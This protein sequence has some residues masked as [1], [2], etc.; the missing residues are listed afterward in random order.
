MYMR[1][2]LLYAAAAIILLFVLSFLV[3]NSTYG[4]KRIAGYL[5]R[6]VKNRFGLTLEIG[7]F[8]YDWYPLAVRLKDLSI[9]GS[10]QKTFFSAR[11]VTVSIPYSSFRSN[12]FVVREIVVDSPY[13]DLDHLPRF[14]SSTGGGTN[15]HLER[16]IIKSGELIVS[17]RKLEHINAIAIVDPL[18][19]VLPQVSAT[20]GTAEISAR[21]SISDFKRYQFQYDVKGNASQISELSKELPP[22][23]GNIAAKGK[24]EGE[25]G[26]FTVTGYAEAGS[27]IVEGSSPF[28]L[29]AEYS[30]N[31]AEKE[32]PYSIKLNWKSLPWN[33]LQKYDPGLP[34]MGT[35]I[36]GSLE[37][38]GGTDL[39]NGACTIQAQLEKDGSNKPP[40]VGDLQGR[41]VKQSL[42]LQSSHLAIRSTRAE[43]SGI[44]SQSEMRL[45]VRA[46]SAALS[47][48]AFLSPKLSRIAGAYQFTGTLSGPYSRIQAKGKLVGRSQELNVESAGSFTIGSNLLDLTFS[49]S[50]SGSAIKRLVSPEIDGSLVFSGKANGSLARPKIQADLS[51]SELAIKGIQLGAVDATLESDGTVMNAIGHFPA[52]STNAEG[53]YHFSSEKYELQAHL[54]DT[55]VEPFR[56]LLPDTF[57]EYSGNL[58]A[59]LNASG[60]LSQLK[61][62]IATLLIENASMK[63]EKWEMTLL[64]DSKIQVE[65]EM[66]TVDARAELPQGTFH[67]E[68]TASLMEGHSMNLHATGDTN[69]SIFALLMPDI[70]VS[71]PISMDA[72]INGTFSKPNFSGTIRTENL[73]LSLPSQNLHLTEGNLIGEFSGTRVLLKGNALINDAAVSVDGTIPFSHEKGEV[74]LDLH[75]FP[76]ATL[77]PDSKIDGTVDVSA[78]F[79]GLGFPY[80]DLSD[81]ISSNSPL[82]DWDGK[83]TIT[84]SNLKVG[85]RVLEAKQPLTFLLRNG[86]LEVETWKLTSGEMLDLAARGNVRFDTGTIDAALRLSVKVDLLSSLRA[87]I[88]SDG[89]LSV[90]VN[91]GGTIAKPEYSGS[92]T[93]QN[94]SLRIPN[95]QMALEQ[96]QLHAPFDKDH[97]TI[98]TL[99]A[100]AG[101]G[102]IT[103]GGEI[104]LSGQGGSKRIW[105]KG[106]NVG[107]GYPVGLRSQLDFD[108]SLG[109]VGKEFLLSGDVDVLR[110][111]YSDDFGLKN[112]LLRTLL[113]NRKEFFQRGYLRSFVKLALKIKTIDNFRL[114]NNLGLVRASADLQL[115]GTLV[116]PRVSGKVEVQGGSRVYF[117]GRRYDVESGRVDFYGTTTLQPELNVTLATLVQDYDNNT[118]YEITLPI[119]GPY[120]KLEYRNPRSTPSLSEDQIYSLLLTGSTAGTQ[121]AVSPAL[122]FQREMVAFLSGQLFFGAEEKFAKTFGLSRINVEQNLL[123]TGNSTDARLILGKDFGTSFTFTYSFPLS[124]PEDQTW[125][126][127]YRYHRNFVFR[128]IRQ[129]DNSVTASARQTILFGK[130]VSYRSLTASEEKKIEEPRIS[131]LKLINDSPVNDPEVRK[132]IKMSEGDL[133]DYWKLQDNLE[134]LEKYLQDKGYLFPS[135]RIEEEDDHENNSVALTIRISSGQ[136]RAMTFNG[137]KIKRGQWDR[138]RTWWREGISENL[139]IGL[140]RKDLL[141][142][143][144]LAGFHQASVNQTSQ[145]QNGMITYVF[146]IEPGIQFTSIDI[147]FSG[148]Q[149]YDSEELKSE[150]IQFY[151]SYTEMVTE[152]IHDF[153]AFQE[154]IEAAY[155]QKG[156]LQAEPSAGPLSI[157][158]SAGT[159]V[160]VTNIVEGPYT[161]IAK[162]VISDG[163]QFPSQLQNLLI[164]QPGDVLKL[165]K[166]PE[167]ETIIRNYYEGRGY[168]N[169]ELGSDLRR[170]EGTADLIVT[171][172]MKIGSISK[173]ASIQIVGNEITRTSLIEDRLGFKVGDI[174]TD[175]KMTE[176]QK[177]L[178]DL[179]VFQDVAMNTEPAQ[180]P[181]EIDLIIHIVEGKKYELQYG[182]RYNTESGI[183][184]EVNLIDQ[185]FLGRAQRLSIYGRYDSN[186]PLYRLDYSIPRLSGFWSNTLASIFYQ[187]LEERENGEFNGQDYDFLLDTTVS[188][189][190]LQQDRRFKDVFRILY[191]VQAGSSSIKSDEPLPVFGS[192][193]I[194]G[195]FVAFGSSLYV[196]TRN[197]PLNAKRGQFFSIGVSYAPS[198]GTDIRFIRSYNQYFY[199]KKLGPVIW[200]SGIRAGFLN[201]LSTE[202]TLDERFQTGGSNTVRGF[203][204]NKL[205]PQD[206]FV[207]AVFGGEAV[208]ILNQEI[209]FPI[210][211]WLGGAVF[212][213]GGNVYSMVKDFDPL[214]L[215]NTGGFGLR[216]DSPYIVLRFDVGFNFDPIND[217]PR[218]VFHFGIGQAF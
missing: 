110:S 20:Y 217:E 192:A 67:L 13:C 194:N 3:L 161:H 173:I 80:E 129:E 177:R 112:R 5:V 188:A 117:H 184:A 39:V 195:T 32:S 52:I 44:V 127:S 156:L 182:P 216:L 89:P 152:A 33:L 7:S 15:F 70:A 58:T 27:L 99:T 54:L 178:Y 83:L 103:G 86:V 51:S 26:A 205:T 124:T 215:R 41:L 153:S 14:P 90:Y 206:N 149:N 97:L 84:P 1:K 203:G 180:N 93:I 151:D 94:A 73:D 49:G 104:Y 126:I 185:N 118:F 6:Y 123:S 42:E 183:G 201:T 88:Q 12:Q 121:G 9:G 74:H 43:F 21:G 96:V 150:M 172:N 35:R 81:G 68:G 60:N 2:K 131:S 62:S 187:V 196:D 213:D 120:N 165:E 25:I 66:V 166:L 16:V 98:E 157:D 57:K 17:Q 18:T 92:V 71:G 114:N 37:Y 190:Q 142:S 82:W 137:W 45:N 109:L 55:S 163:Q 128:T 168:R 214:N 53:T 28:A 186:Q 24:V 65:K 158:A 207:D 38:K 162:I 108:V 113:S 141:Q 202:F 170:E 135:V 102:T 122:L 76:V 146:N 29:N 200:A 208:F 34:L 50:V 23:S 111:A 159:I 169:L 116:Q 148:N 164:V 61:K 85:E 69:A 143:L 211:K 78:D 77:L 125:I 19:T 91:V 144:W 59:E 64:P 48:L 140:I 155:V 167:N 136:Q 175:Q 130:G 10:D 8:D 133:Y 209:R 181:G 134:G 87:D 36:N 154:K 191:G 160:R 101:G 218:V 22:M 197:D 105:L 171:Y 115:N 30:M 46:T 176:A 138:Y 210:Y 199:Y 189:V 139:V 107:L 212:Y 179:G 75:S 198:I 174:L 79:E 106:S 204:T 119:V 63:S 100:H 145:D 147:Q 31:Q 193:S 40:L 132:K 47:D 95:F 11:S 72:F 4:K 56:S